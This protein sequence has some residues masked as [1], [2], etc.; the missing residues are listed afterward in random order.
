[1]PDLMRVC[2]LAVRM[3]PVVRSMVSV[4]TVGITLRH[5]RSPV[6]HWVVFTEHLHSS[7]SCVLHWVQF[8]H[9]L[10]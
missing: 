9:V 4:T 7:T 6:M 10:S 5:T 2:C 3:L 1:M 8:M